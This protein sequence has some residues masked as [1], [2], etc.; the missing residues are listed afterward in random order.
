MTKE[1]HD[2]LLENNIKEQELDNNSTINQV[3]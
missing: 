3:F 2:Q 1:K